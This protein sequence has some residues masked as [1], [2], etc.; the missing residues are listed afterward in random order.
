MPRVRVRKTERGLKPISAYEEAYTEI[1]ANNTANNTI[2][3]T[4]EKFKLHYVSLSRFVKKKKEA[5][6]QG[7]AIPVSMGYR[8]VRRVFD[9]NQEKIFVGYIIKAAQIFF[10]LP[11]K[12]IRKLAFQ[13]AV[14]Y[15]LR[16]PDTWKQNSMAGEDW[17]SGFMKR[18]PELSI[19]CAQATSLSRATSFN[20]TNVKLFYD[21]L[22]NVIDRYKFE[23]KDI[24]NIDEKGTKQ[25]VARDQLAKIHK[26]LHNSNDPP[27]GSGN[28]EE[29]TPTP[30]NSEL[31]DE[32]FNYL[33]SS[34]DESMSEVSNWS[35]QGTYLGQSYNLREKT[36]G[37]SVYY[38]PKKVEKPQEKAGKSSKER[39]SQE[40]LNNIEIDNQQQGKN[41]VHISPTVIVKN[42]PMDIQGDTTSSESGNEADANPNITEGNEATKDYLEKRKIAFGKIAEERKKP[43]K[44]RKNVMVQQALS[45]NMYTMD[46]GD[47]RKDISRFQVFSFGNAE[48]FISKSWTCRQGSP[49]Y[50]FFAESYIHDVFA[51]KTDFIIKAK[52]YRRRM[53]VHTDSMYK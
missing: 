27:Q 38:G 19:R 29:V 42:D 6:E 28:K 23:P 40:D 33:A 35:E 14:K 7:S 30:D 11:P 16:I 43:S 4:A 47:W 26:S 18:N 44:Q 5:I 36:E 25:G 21:N 2:R 22:L 1:T 41:P 46:Y 24:Y 37:K 50:K 10:G 20:V 53:K 31:E 8:C 13:L 45:S 49:G 12:E 51:H 32:Y 15:S 52:C 9:V 17:F 39:K 48:F 3:C 34:D